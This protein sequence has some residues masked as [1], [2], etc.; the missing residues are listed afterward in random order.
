MDVLEA[1]SKDLHIPLLNNSEWTNYEALN[2]EKTSSAV[3]DLSSGNCLSRKDL[4]NCEKD[5]DENGA[6]ARLSSR[7][8]DVGTIQLV[9]LC[10]FLTAGGPFGVEKCVL[11]CGISPTIIGLIAMPFLYVFPQILMT[12]ELSTMM[13]ENGSYVIWVCR[14]CGQFWGWINAFNSIL[15]NLFDTAIYPVLVMDYWL[16][17]Y[18]DSLTHGE[19]LAIKMGIVLAGA[20]I[21]IFRVRFIGNISCIFTFIVVSPF[22]VGFCLTIPRITPSKQWSWFPPGND[23]R[24]WVVFLSTLLWLHN[25]WDSL[26]CVAGE[27]KNGSKSYI[28]AVFICALINCLVYLIAIVSAATVP[29]AGIPSAKV[30]GDAYLL[31]VNEYLFPGFGGIC[32]AVVCAIDN[33]SMYF[34][35]M[36]TT[37]RGLMIMADDGRDDQVEQNKLAMMPGFIGFEWK[38]TSSPVIAI[39][40]QSM[41]ILVLIQ[42]DFTL[43]IEVDAFANSI[44]LLLKFVSFIRLRYTEPEAK[45]PYKVPGGLCVAWTITVMKISSIITIIVLMVQRW[46]PLICIV[47]YNVFIIIIYFV[48]AKVLSRRKNTPI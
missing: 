12:A 4:E 44:C 29:T 22:V 26:S 21:N 9:A 40:V 1:G 30:W 17:L 20:I 15:F 19:A 2:K 5:K 13:P 6:A 8:R 14:G 31:D 38:K 33:I 32:I 37:S 42:F 43:L 10:F 45:R 28:K 25:G 46:K 3:N 18:P 23:D 16:H 41:M 48:R 27:V 35:A 39:L 11:S 47:V 34:V 36:S 24:D 7:L